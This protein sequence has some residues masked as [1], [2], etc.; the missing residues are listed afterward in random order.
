MMTSELKYA[1][2]RFHFVL[3]VLW[4]LVGVMNLIIMGFSLWFQ[5][6]WVP[7]FYGLLALLCCLNGIYYLRLTRITYIA[8]DET[9]LLISR[10]LVL[11]KRFVSFSEVEDQRLIGNTFRMRLKNG[12]E[13]GIKYD[14]LSLNDI[15]ILEEAV[16]SGTGST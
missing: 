3:G 9:G 12:R 7:F 10:G 5:L 1:P 15:K 14:L 2:N 13:I 16:R 11:R 4:V 6:Q 8:V